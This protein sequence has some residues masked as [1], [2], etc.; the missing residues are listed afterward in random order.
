MACVVRAQA[1]FVLGKFESMGDIR[2]METE[3]TLEQLVT[4]LGGST[5]NR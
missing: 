1:V 4:L 5:S 2:A 3:L